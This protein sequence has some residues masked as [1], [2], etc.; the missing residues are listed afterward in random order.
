[1]DPI[2]FENTSA[3]N[4]QKSFFTFNVKNALVGGT[5]EKTKVI[6]TVTNVKDVIATKPLPARIVQH[7]EFDVKRDF[8]K[9]CRGIRAYTQN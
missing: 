5:P 9:E 6:V 3:S 7:V 1:M 2:S 4:G 8:N